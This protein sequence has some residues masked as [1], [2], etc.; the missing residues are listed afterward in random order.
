MLAKTHLAFGFFLSLIITP[1]LN[2]QN[3]LIFTLIIL[4]GSVLPDIDNP[5]NFFGFPFIGW[6]TKHRGIFHSIYLAA[7]FPLILAYFTNL[8]YG[9]A[10]FIGYFSHLVFDSLTKSGIN[11]LHPFSSFKISGFIETGSIIE[12]II[13]VF[14]CTAIAVKLF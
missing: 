1:M 8:S 4:L 13:F 7:L 5:K 12:Y 6:F 11:F 3:S 9:I 14:L 2:M 10:L